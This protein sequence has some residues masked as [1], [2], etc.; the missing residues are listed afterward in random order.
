[1]TRRRLII[2]LVALLAVIAGYSWW[3]LEAAGQVRLGIA[4]WADERRAAGWMVDYTL[5]VS[6]YP[7]S[8]NAT[9]DQPRIVAESGK[10]RWQG[11]RITSH[12]AP[13]RLSQ[14]TVEFPGT[15]VVAIPATA[16][17]M[18]VVAAKATGT[19]EVSVAGAIEHI[20]AEITGVSL[21]SPD[22]GSFR[23]DRLA[24]RA[25]EAPP[26]ARPQAGS[27]TPP[28]GPTVVAEIER[29][30]LPDTIRGALGQTVERASLNAQLTGRL[31]PGQPLKDAVVAW[32]DQGGTLEIRELSG[33]WGPLT[34][35]AAGTLALDGNMQPQGALNARAR[36][37]NE[38]VDAL[39]NAGLV[40]RRAG[41]NVKVA[42]GVLGK[43]PQG[44]GPPEITV[45]VT[46]QNSW[47]YLGPVGLLPIPPLAWD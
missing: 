27:P 36:G 45:P 35:A 42:F 33:I 46:V 31:P 26:D 14:V 43:Q 2:P 23:A 28:P 1:M 17:E 8:L 21:S 20:A 37:Y 10:W 38:T 13:W 29:L 18:T 47:I 40:N 4:R 41:A 44:G 7:F 32:R 11:P 16:P 12:A 15:H 22:Y 34:I 5:G 9:I 39:V 19:A 25:T 30:V 3:W 6:G 24:L